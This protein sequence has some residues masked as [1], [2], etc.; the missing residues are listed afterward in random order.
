MISCALLLWNAEPIRLQQ[1]IAEE[2]GGTH[3]GFRFVYCFYETLWLLGDCFDAHSQM[4]I[5]CQCQPTFVNNMASLIRGLSKNWIIRIHVRYVH[6]VETVAGKQLDVQK[7]KVIRWTCNLD[8]CD[9]CLH[10]SVRFSKSTVSQMMP[11]VATSN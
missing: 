8:P 11:H 2:F 10:Q 6:T 4:L 1:S 5:D 7:S 3:M 9:P